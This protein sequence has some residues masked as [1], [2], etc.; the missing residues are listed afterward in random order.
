MAVLFDPERKLFTLHTRH[1]TYQMK[2]GPCG[3]LLHLYYG[4]RAEGDMSYV[5][6]FRDRGFSGNPYD[7]GADRTV[8]ADVLPQEYPCEGSGDYRPTAFSLR[9]ANG[10]SGCDLRYVSHEIHHGLPVLSGLPAVHCAEEEGETLVITL[11]DPSAGAT[12][13][14][15]YG[16]LAEADAITRSAKIVNISDAPIVLQNAASCALDLPGGAWDLIHF[17]GRHEGERAPER[18]PIRHAAQCIGSRRG[19]SSHQHNPFVILADENAGEDGG[20]C[21]GAML[22]YSGSFACTAEQDPFGL[23]RLVLG[24][25][26]EQFD[27][28]LQPFESF[29]TPEAALILTSR[30]LADLSHRFHSMILHHVCRGPWVTR[31]RPVLINNWE[32]TGM[33][34]D[35]ECLLRIARRAAELGVEMMVLDDGWFG[36]RSDDNAGL[37]D[38]T[39]NETKLGGTMGS[40]A[41]EIRSLGMKFGL[42]IEPEMVNEDSDLYRAHPDWA[43]VIPGKAPVR[44]RN[45]LVLDFSRSEVVDAVF[46]RLCTVLDDCRPDYIKMDMNRSLADVYTASAG[47]QSRGKVLDGYVRGVYR[48]LEMLLQRYPALLLEGC[49]GGG[50]RFD[51][52]MLYYCPQIWCSDNTDAVDRIRIQYGTS[53]G[54]PVSTM[55]AHVSAVPNYATGRVTP[56]QTRAAV[57]M[58]GTF[59]YELDLDLLTD[60]EKEQVRQQIRTFKKYEDL[61][62]FGDYYRLTDAVQDHEAAAWMSADPDGNE[63]LVT[64]VRLLATGNS[65]A[66]FIRLKG[67]L[68]DAIYRDEATGETYSGSALMHLGL[69]VPY[70]PKGDFLSVRIHLEREQD[71]NEKKRRPIWQNISLMRKK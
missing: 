57:A 38:W 11:E 50:G 1:T 42:W 26:S 61:I 69:P 5:L 19:M 59:G 27:Y 56:L 37:G 48:F 53:F 64:I 65:P 6:S 22:L 44:S 43:F 63:A 16:V 33:N 3:I 31:P 8:S 40:L 14:L 68:P 51:A 66:R 46:A 52:G 47:M 24:V 58:S 20:L 32:A 55:G 2:L 70:A 7:A 29:Q 39:V 49:A 54:Y 60:G 45:Q 10:V 41:G 67:L 30:G 23:T 35:K 12:V 25:Q 17:H 15:S 9:R 71:P 4:P 13:H 62:R 36:S 18:A 34:F 21:A 28:E